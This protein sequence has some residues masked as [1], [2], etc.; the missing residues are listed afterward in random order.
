MARTR[1]KDK[2]SPKIK[3]SKGIVALAND[4]SR[5]VKIFGER[6]IAAPDIAIGSC[7]S[8]STSCN[9]RLQALP[10]DFWASSR[11]SLPVKSSK[12][13]PLPLHGLRPPRASRCCSI[14]A[15]VPE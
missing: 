6:G 8:A 4:V 13:S 7:E 1:R 15:C 2:W 10:A 3:F 11:S 14:L 9:T 12:A 5:A